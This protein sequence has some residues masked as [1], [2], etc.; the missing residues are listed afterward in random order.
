MDYCVVFQQRGFAYFARKT[1]NMPERAEASFCLDSLFP[2]SSR[3]K[4]KEKMSPVTVG[5]TRLT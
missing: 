5:K 2:F 1:S 3:R 4:E